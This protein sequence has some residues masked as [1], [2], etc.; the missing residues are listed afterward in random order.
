MVLWPKKVV[1]GDP[2]WDRACALMKVLA[3]DPR[4]PLPLRSRW[5]V[6]R[7]YF[8][9]ADQFLERPTIVVD[10][11]RVAAPYYAYSLR[12]SV[13]C[14]VIGH[15]P[16]DDAEQLAE[17][18]AVV[19]E[20]LQ[21]SLTVA[22]RKRWIATEEWRKRVAANDPMAEVFSS[23]AHAEGTKASRYYSEVQAAIQGNHAAVL[24]GLI[25][26]GNVLRAAA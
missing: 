25:D 21:D 16:V 7:E 11:Q 8:S 18:R 22:E 26:I 20:A 10:R 15:I 2:D 23:E 6:P 1:Q 5:G 19:N 24:E 3:L 9:S 4:R 14:S 17:F 12:F 13:S